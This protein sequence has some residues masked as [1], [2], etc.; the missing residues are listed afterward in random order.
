MF[1]RIQTSSEPV[2]RPLD[3]EALVARLRVLDDVA[4]AQIEDDLDFFHFTGFA[5]DRLKALFDTAAPLQSA[6]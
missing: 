3:M 4:L 2:S 6:A 1:D 5:S